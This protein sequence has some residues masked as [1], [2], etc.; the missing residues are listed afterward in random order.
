MVRED[1]CERWHQVETR[2]TR[3]SQLGKDLAEDYRTSG[4][5]QTLS[6]SCALLGTKF[7]DLGHCSET[8]HCSGLL[9]KSILPDILCIYLY[10]KKSRKWQK[11]T[12][13]YRL[14]E[15]HTRLKW[16]SRHTYVCVCVYI[17]I[18]SVTYVYVSTCVAI[19]IHT[20]YAWWE[21]SH[22][23]IIFLLKTYLIW[24]WFL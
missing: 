13:T 18:Y 21:K 9:D 19:D 2:R 12:Y 14:V 15:S 24:N 11:Y 3:E 10:C 8:D 4:V 5:V 23:Q 6:V 20:W 7:W 17:C 1:L 22:L 16:L